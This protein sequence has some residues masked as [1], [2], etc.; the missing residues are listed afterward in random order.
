LCQTKKI[1]T[2]LAKNQTLTCDDYYPVV[3]QDG[4]QSYDSCSVGLIACDKKSGK[5]P[6][7]FQ[8]GASK[9]DDEISGAVVF[10][11]GLVILII[12]LIGLVTLLQKMLLGMSTRIL[13][14]ATNVNGYIAI[15]IGAAITILVQSSSITTSALTPFAGMG[16]LRLEQMLPLTLGA[17]IGTTVTG[18]LA[19]L[20]SEGTNSLQVA[21]CHLFF[22]ISGI[23]VWYP[24]PYMRQFPLNAAKRLGKVTRVWRGFPILYIIVIFGIVPVMLLGLSSLFTQGSKGFTVLGSLITVI[25]AIVLLYITYKW[26]KGGLKERT[27]ERFEKRQRNKNTLSTL[28]DDMEY[29]KSEIVRLRDHTGLE[30]TEDGKDEDLSFA[31]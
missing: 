7:F 13:Y 8:D 30:E 25:L 15:V 3:C 21:L 17:N 10:V 18:L 23:I 31:P 26:T 6:A 19:S 28:D 27:I 24:I 9:R 12:C 4:I 1:S 16:A 14:K 11:L 20:V 5:C 29:L 2:A 22:N